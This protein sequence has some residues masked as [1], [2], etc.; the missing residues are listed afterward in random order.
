M[1][2]AWEIA[3]TLLTLNAPDGGSVAFVKC[4]GG[5]IGIARDG[6]PLPDSRWTEN[7]LTECLNEFIRLAGLKH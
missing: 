3:Q 6:V 5:G 4:V 1:P 7:Q 2:H